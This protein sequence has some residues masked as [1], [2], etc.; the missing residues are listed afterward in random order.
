MSAQRTHR[1]KSASKPNKTVSLERVLR[2]LA[3]GPVEYAPFAD[4]VLLHAPTGTRLAVGAAWAEG[5]SLGLY[6][7]SGSAVALTDAGH[8]RLRRSGEGAERFAA[9]HRDVARRR[10]PSRTG[11]HD[12]SVNRNESPLTRLHA[13]KDAAGRPWIGDA[14]LLAGERLRRDFDRSRIAPRM[15]ASW[16]PTAR[17]APRTG[18]GG[19][20][21]ES[22]HAIDAKRRMQDALDALD[23]D[24]AGVALDV[25]CYLKGLETVERERRWPARSAKLML[26]T[27]LSQLAVR[28]G[29][30][31]GQ[32]RDGSYARRIRT[33]RVDGRR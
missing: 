21:D 5:L 13:R 27:A 26:R 24:L 20:A 30:N 14:E 7:T 19:A 9:Q 4:T 10:I 23:P 33:S 2:F 11:W 18:A 15:S 17:C 25:C 31:A 6:S 8:A 32:R 3:D 28:Y 12:A 16:D 22:D 29:M 1:P